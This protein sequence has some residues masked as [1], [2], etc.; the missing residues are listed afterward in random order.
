METIRVTVWHHPTLVWDWEFSHQGNHRHNPQSALSLTLPFSQLSPRCPPPCSSQPCPHIPLPCHEFSPPTT[1]Q[2]WLFWLTVSLI[3]WLSEFH[4]VWF[5]G[6]SGCLLFFNL[7]LSFWLYE[8][9]KDFYLCLHVGQ[10]SSLNFLKTDFQ[11]WNFWVIRQ[12]N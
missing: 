4:A 9:V 12:L 2:V 11:K 10:N 8:Q 3:P 1:L 5:S 6:T 7:L